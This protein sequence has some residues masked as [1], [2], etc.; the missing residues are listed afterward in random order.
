MT[1]TKQMLIAITAATVG[2]LLTWTSAIAGGGWW[3]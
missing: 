3:G 2:M 1:R